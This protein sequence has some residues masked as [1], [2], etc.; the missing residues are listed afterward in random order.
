MTNKHKNPVL[1]FTRNCLTSNGTYAGKEIPGFPYIKGQYIPL[2]RR[3]QATKLYLVAQ[4]RYR[5]ASNSGLWN[6]PF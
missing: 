6:G 4:D 2:M 5:L 3:A 1:W